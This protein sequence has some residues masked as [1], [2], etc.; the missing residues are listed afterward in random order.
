ME[1]KYKNKPFNLFLVHS[2]LSES[3]TWFLSLSKIS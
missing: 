1:E 2:G 3:V